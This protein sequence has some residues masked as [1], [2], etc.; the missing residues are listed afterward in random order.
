MKNCTRENYQQSCSV[1]LQV[2]SERRKVPRRCRNIAASR[3]QLSCD[4]ITV[5]ITGRRKIHEFLSSIFMRIFKLAILNL[6]KN[7]NHKI[8]IVISIIDRFRYRYKYNRWNQ[9]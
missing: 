7:S 4:A 1:K 5:F 3:A 9:C 6:K 2:P 8:L